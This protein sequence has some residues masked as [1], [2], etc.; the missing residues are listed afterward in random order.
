MN[1]RNAAP[2]TTADP[3]EQRIRLDDCDLTYF[4]RHPEL[5]GR[6]PTLFFVH[7][8]GFHARVW[9]GII[10][11]LPKMHS[12]ALD[13]RG[14]G[15]SEKKAIDH[16]RIMGEDQAALAGA[17]DLADIL[18]VGHSMG[19]HAMID[20]AALCPE[21]FRRLVLIDPVVPAPEAYS[22]GAEFWRS[23]E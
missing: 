19:A 8:T 16:W 12:I 10:A 4:E 22:G 11:R 23:W 20:A 3:A 7:A 21:R 9:D 13:Q 6:G 2:D 14:H 18:G 17:L 1:V 15:R 5:A